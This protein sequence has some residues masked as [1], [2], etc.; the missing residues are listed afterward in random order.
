MIV[1][2]HNNKHNKQEK[3][4]MTTKAL[5]HTALISAAL[6]MSAAS[7]QAQTLRLNHNNPEDHPTHVSMQYMSRMVFRIIVVQPQCLGLS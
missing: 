3:Q 4:L 2:F 6:F 1:G 7:A 5:R